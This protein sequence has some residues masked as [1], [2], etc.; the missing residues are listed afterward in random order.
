MALI[1]S[2]LPLFAHIFDFVVK[3]THVIIFDI[4]NSA[5]DTNVNKLTL[6]VGEV[7]KVLQHL[8]SH[9]IKVMFY[10][11]SSPSSISC[12]NFKVSK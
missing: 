5:C 7:S 3:L 1:L 12:R 10:L 4:L 6:G 11:H 8:P 9:T 2:Y